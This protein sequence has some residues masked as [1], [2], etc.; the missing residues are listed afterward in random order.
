MTPEQRWSAALNA[1]EERVV[2]LHAAAN[3]DVDPVLRVSTL[4]DTALPDDLG[5]VPA[6]LLPRASAVLT[7]VQA[8]E[9]DLMSGMERLSHEL[10]RLSMP[11]Q[12]STA[13][14][15]LFVD[16]AL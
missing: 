1:L 13:P 16:Q 2:A 8:L 10:T 4:P 6:R 7:L 9:A 12:P 11:R 5:P 15:P 14:T 3:S